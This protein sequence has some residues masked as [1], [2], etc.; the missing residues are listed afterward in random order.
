MYRR[1]LNELLLSVSIQHIG[2]TPSFIGMGER[3]L[4]NKDPLAIPNSMTTNIYI[5][6]AIEPVVLTFMNN[7]QGVCV[8]TRYA[9]LHTAAAI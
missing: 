4:Y 2:L 7:I 3:I 9:R 8:L 5:S 6:V 1:K